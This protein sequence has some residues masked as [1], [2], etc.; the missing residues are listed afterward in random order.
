MKNI[1]IQL[2][3][4][5][6]EKILLGN[7]REEIKKAMNKT[8]RLISAKRKNNSSDNSD[9]DSESIDSDNESDYCEDDFGNELKIKRYCSD[10][11]YL[12]KL[13]F[14]HRSWKENFRDFIAQYNI[15][16]DLIKKSVYD[17]CF[18][19]QNKGLNSKNE[20]KKKKRK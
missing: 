10:K 13:V 12:K 7:K 14:E 3:F 4:V 18:N 5:N 8:K 2:F 17:D 19:S 15:S 1:T 16:H 11:D 20:N 9:V 6:I